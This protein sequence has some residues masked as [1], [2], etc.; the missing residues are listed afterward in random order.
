MQ[1]ETVHSMSSS[2]NE[3]VWFYSD[4]DKEKR[5]SCEEMIANKFE[6]HNI[7]QTK[8]EMDIWSIFSIIVK[9]TQYEH[10]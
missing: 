10:L 2:S 6:T 5:T 7:D 9:Y 1:H 3:N 8:P 4:T